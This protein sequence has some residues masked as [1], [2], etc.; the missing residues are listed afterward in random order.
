[1]KIL[2]KMVDETG[3]LEIRVFFLQCFREDAR[4]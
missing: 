1:M 2:K 3:A 4:H